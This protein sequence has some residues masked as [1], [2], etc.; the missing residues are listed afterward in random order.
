MA[1]LLE[2]AAQFHDLAI[3]SEDGRAAPRRERGNGR[4]AI[5]ITAR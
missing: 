3:I 1:F 4:Q 5:E 2:W